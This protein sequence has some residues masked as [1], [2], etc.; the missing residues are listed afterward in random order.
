MPRA[1][2]VHY[3][4]PSAVS[5]TPNANGSPDDLAV[6]VA[7]GSKI[8]VYSPKAGIDLVDASFQEWT[9]AG[10]NRRLGDRTKPYTIYARLSKQNKNDGYRVFAQKSE[11]GGRWVDKYSCVTTEGLSVLYQDNG[12]DVVVADNNYW[13]IRLGDV[14]LPDSGKRTVTLDT[15]IVGTDQFN[16]EWNIDADAMSRRLS[17][18]QS[19]MGLIGRRDTQT[20]TFTVMYGWQDITTDYRF[21]V[22]R[23]S[24]DVA[25]DAEWNAQHTN[26]GA[27]WTMNYSDLNAATCSFTVTARSLA[28]NTELTGDF[29]VRRSN[30]S[31]RY[32]LTVNTEIIRVDMNGDLTGSE[33]GVRLV[34][35]DVDND[36]EDKILM[37]GDSQRR[38]PCARRAGRTGGPR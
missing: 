29:I 2:K 14:S 22:S 9:M 3:I 25:A 26:T 18:T 21:S 38:R 7:R 27:S 8:K 4:A 19:L 20:V 12:F 28:D 30:D 17:I 16:E 35:S 37:L 6:Y 34:R 15:G 23:Y 11:R 31:L 24:G 10:R 36:G 1:S 33:S 5:I 13:Y 32:Y